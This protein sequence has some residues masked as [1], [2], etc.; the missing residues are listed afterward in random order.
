MNNSLKK[1]KFSDWLYVI[2]VGIAF[3]F[4][5]VILFLCFFESVWCDEVFSLYIIQGSYLDILINTAVDVHPPLYY[6]ILKFFTDVIGGVFPFINVVMLTK[7]ISFSSITILFYFSV[8]KLTKVINKNIVSL[9][10]LIFFGVS[11]ISDFSITVR[12]YGFALLFVFVALYYLIR[13]IKFNQDKDWKRF[14]LFFELSALTHYFALIAAGAM[15]VYLLFYV[16]LNKKQDFWK[17]YKYLFYAIL[18][19]VPWLVVFI[20]QFAYISSFGFWITKPDSSGIFSII[21]YGFA[22]KVLGAKGTFE[23]VLMLVVFAIY[24]ALFVSN[25]LNKKL[26]KNEKWIAFSGMFVS[27]FLYA[28]GLAVSILITPVFVERYANPIFGALCLSFGYNI[29]LFMKHYIVDKLKNKNILKSNGRC[30]AAT[31][32]T[33]LIAITSIYSL[34]NIINNVK[35]EQINNDNFVKNAQFFDEHKEDI[36]ISDYGRVQSVFEYSHN[37][38][39][40]GIEGEDVSWWENVTLLKHKAY[41]YESIKTQLESNKTVIL[42]HTTI[43]LEEFG[44]Y[45][46]NCHKIDE[47]YIESG[48]VVDIYELKLGA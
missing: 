17:W 28:F 10:L 35:H 34:F 6:F 15:F 21:N 45:N 46:I 32:A 48:D 18:A 12:M 9:F 42:L 8:F 1:W 4:L 20:C 44:K 41:N 19:F 11:A 27:L 30:V 16:L 40:D 38:N 26:D 39:I 31:F 29:Y 2:S 23:N 3:C 43:D 7:V 47:L 22:P 25:C 33:L 37:V 5:A 14:V 24:F 36:L 13:I